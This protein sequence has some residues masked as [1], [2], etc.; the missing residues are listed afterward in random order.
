MRFDWI[1]AG[2]GTIVFR[3]LEM[4]RGWCRMPYP[5]HPQGCPNA[6]D[7]SLFLDDLQ[8]RVRLASRVHLVWVVFDLDEQERR[9]AEIHPDWTSRQCRNL[10]Y[11]QRGVRRD[12]REAASTLFP[13]G[14]LVIG[15]EG[16]GVDFYLTM[17]RIGVPLDTMRDLH[18]VR[19]I[20]IVLE[21]GQSSQRAISD[22]INGGN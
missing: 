11:W 19:V 20:G 10:L 7:C 4:V 9:M 12:L 5:G 15:A 21:N 6:G 2:K 22:Y 1:A 17:R 8:E 18:D 13:H 16:G 3:P 14:D